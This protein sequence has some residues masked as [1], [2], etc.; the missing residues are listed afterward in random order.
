MRK[1]IE[2]RERR[3]ERVEREV[4]KKTEERRNERGEREVRKKREER[5]E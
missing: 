5:R 3:N 1:K 4:I 2:E